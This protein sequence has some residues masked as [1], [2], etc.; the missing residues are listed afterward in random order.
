MT[1]AKPKILFV[2]DEQALLDGVKRGLRSFAANWDMTFLSDPRKAFDLASSNGFDVIVSDLRMPGLGGLDLLGELRKVGVEAQAI[3]LT[4]TGDMETA[5]QAINAVG[6]FRYYTKPCPALSLAEGIKEALAKALPKK[7]TGNYAQAALDALPLA[8][9]AVNTAGKILYSNRK[10][11]ELL[12]AK[13]PILADANGICRAL[14]PSETHSLHQSLMA[15]ARGGVP[16]VLALSGLEEK[17][18]SALIE[19][20]NGQEDETAAL[21]FVRLLDSKGAPS[22]AAL[23]ELFGLSPTEARLAHE[24]ATGLDV[25]EAAAALGVTVNTAR[26]YLRTIFQKTNVNR[27]SELIRLLTSSVAG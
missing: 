2:D 5:I 13:E 6:V 24:L 26:T 11:E 27:Q 23:K 3:V 1:D 14:T 7:N 21:M 20:P 15:V 16:V 25:K 22:P 12:G 8:A 10:G 19:P 17:R 9:L 4:G 18:Y